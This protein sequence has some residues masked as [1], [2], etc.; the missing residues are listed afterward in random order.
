MKA[1]FRDTFIHYS[2]SHLFFFFSHV[3]LFIFSV[4]TADGRTE[5]LHVGYFFPLKVHELCNYI[6]IRAIEAS[7]CYYMI[8]IHRVTNI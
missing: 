8:I 6:V 5:S 2:N 7:E 3:F 1:S 4:S